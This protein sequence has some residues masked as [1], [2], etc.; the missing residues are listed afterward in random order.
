MTTDIQNLR[1]SLL[2]VSILRDRFFSR[3]SFFLSALSSFS[4]SFIFY[5]FFFRSCI[6]FLILLYHFISLGNFPQ[7][8]ENN[9]VSLFLSLSQH[10]D[11]SRRRYDNVYEIIFCGRRDTEHDIIGNSRWKSDERSSPC[12]QN[13]ALHLITI[14]WNVPL[15]KNDVDK[16]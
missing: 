6:H 2:P 1:L 3:S 10:R 9:I 12:K 4:L 15:I 11:T 7:A 8:A 5:H 13:L 14:L 16:P